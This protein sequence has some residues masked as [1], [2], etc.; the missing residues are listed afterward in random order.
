MTTFFN[1]VELAPPVEVFALVAAFNDDNHAQK[2]NLSIGGSCRRALCRITG[3]LL[4]NH[5]SPTKHS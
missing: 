5:I 1:S 3:E 2:V 4:P